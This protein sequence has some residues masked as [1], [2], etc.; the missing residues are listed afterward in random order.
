MKIT[1]AIFVNK[2]RVPSCAEEQ[3]VIKNESFN[4]DSFSS[5]DTATSPLDLLLFD[6]QTL[7]HR[8][9]ST[10]QNITLDT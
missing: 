6:L 3:T 1:G 2:N 4:W 5:K 7:S 8:R 10:P 9:P